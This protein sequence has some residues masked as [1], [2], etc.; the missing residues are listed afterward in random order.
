MNDDDR[1]AYGMIDK[2]EAGDK[3]IKV[4]IKKTANF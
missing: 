2:L 4:M 3:T 1:V